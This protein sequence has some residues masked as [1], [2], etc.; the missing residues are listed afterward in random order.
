MPKTDFNVKTLAAHLHMTPSQVEKLANRGNL[1]GRKVGGDWKFTRAE[2][3]HWM[4]ERIGLSDAEE[5]VEVEN[6]LERTATAHDQPMQTIAELIP[7]EAIG[8]PLSART[9][10]SVIRA[11]VD[12]AVGT[13]QLWDPD[14]MIEAVRS[15]EEMHPTALENGVALLHPRRP[16]TSILGEP[17]I[18]L[19]RTPAGIPFGGSGGTLTDVFF[20]ICSTDDRGHLCALARLS[21]ILALPDFLTKLRDEVVD[22][23]DAHRLIKQTEQELP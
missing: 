7:I 18:A 10:G 11:M 5:L 13:G 1:P 2:I 21:R 6:V 19:G 17:L 4:E 9:G 16:M 3:H 23:A 20:L 22:A 12:L 8:I 15:R 14:K